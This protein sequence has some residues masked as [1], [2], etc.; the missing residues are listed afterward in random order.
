MSRR[1]MKT[2]KFV[3]PIPPPRPAYS[4]LKLR[5]LYV[6]DYCGRQLTGKLKQ[7]SKGGWLTI[8]TEFEEFRVRSTAVRRLARSR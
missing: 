6:F 2:P 4:E 1:K 3:M 5:R 8:E 7:K